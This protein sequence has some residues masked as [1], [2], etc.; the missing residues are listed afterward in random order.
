MPRPFRTQ[1]PADTD[2]ERNPPIGGSTDTRM[3][4]ASPEEIE[5]SEGANAI[6]GDIDNDTVS[7]RR[8][9]PSL[10]PCQLR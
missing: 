6:E 3:T 5:A 4:D 9:P 2:P 1:R 10:V 7:A 8:G